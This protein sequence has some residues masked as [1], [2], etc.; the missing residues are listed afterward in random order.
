[1]N[2]PNPERSRSVEGGGQRWTVVEVDFPIS[3]DAMQRC[4]MFSCDAMV[5]KVRSYPADW[6][7]RTESALY[8][9]SLKV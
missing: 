3:A 1:M 6:H 5:R 7:E 4:L 9:V 2:V 8:E